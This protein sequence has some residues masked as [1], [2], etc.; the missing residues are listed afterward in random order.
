MTLHEAAERFQYA[1]QYANDVVYEWD[2]KESISWVG[3]VDELLGYEPGEF[4]R[5]F[6]S[7]LA[8]MD[9]EDAPRLTAAIEAH[10]QRGVP[11]HEEYR[12]RTKQGT[13]RW[14]AAR[15]AA[16]R[17]PDGSPLKWIGSITDVTER[18]QAEEA[19]RASEREFRS[20]A[21]AMPQ[22]VWATRADGW[23]IY[24]NQ[25]WVEYTGLTLEQSGTADDLARAAG[26]EERRDAMFAGE[27]INT[28]EDRAVLHTALRLPRDA[29]LL[30]DG[31]D[32]V[33]DVHEGQDDRPA[34][35]IVAAGMDAS[36]GRSQQV[37]IE[38]DGLFHVSDLEYEAE[39]P[40]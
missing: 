17:A 12:I 31:Q 40:K 4:P 27:H 15:G 16:V 8:A 35:E 9:P 18:K 7:W 14:W 10:L 20:L 6:A 28:S 13:Y 2:L 25:Q 3:K 21:E 29:E 5:T 23:N 1:V 37:H 36:S 11:Y 22:I 38:S 30:V 39:D 19:L 33:A 26:L 34:I 24:F 32:V